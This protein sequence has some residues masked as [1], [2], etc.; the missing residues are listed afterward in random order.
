MYIN[1]GN[2]NMLKRPPDLLKPPSRPTFI[3]F[4]SKQN[5]LLHKCAFHV[6]KLMNSNIF[7]EPSHWSR[8]Q[9]SNFMTIHPQKHILTGYGGH[10]KF[11]HVH[12]NWDC[13]SSRFS[14]FFC[15]SLLYCY[16]L[17]S[18]SSTPPLALAIMKLFATLSS[19]LTMTLTKMKHVCSAEYV[20][21]IQSKC[22]AVKC[23]D[24]VCYVMVCCNIILIFVNGHY[25]LVIN[26]SEQFDRS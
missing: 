5:Q 23:D 17:L 24:N 26:V 18:K 20:N 4:D 22:N 19:W 8:N 6:V 1:V 13:F 2:I 9:T 10:L 14:N 15:C 16:L 21:K 11:V 7:I 12:T 3:D 25:L